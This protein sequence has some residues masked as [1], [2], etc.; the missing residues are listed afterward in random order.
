MKLECCISFKKKKKKQTDHVETE[1]CDIFLKS[2]SQNYIQLWNWCDRKVNSLVFDSKLAPS[3]SAVYLCSAHCDEGRLP[4]TVFK[5]CHS[6]LERHSF[7]SCLF[8]LLVLIQRG[9]TDIYIKIWSQTEDQWKLASK[10]LFTDLRF[11]V[12]S[13]KFYH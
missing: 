2:Q 12:F 11:V 8:L 5:S 3:Q 1:W 13:S 9:E 7:T 4:A 10:W 6:L